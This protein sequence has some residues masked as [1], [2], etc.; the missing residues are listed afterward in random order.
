[1]ATDWSVRAVLDQP[2]RQDELQEN[3]QAALDRVVTEMSQ[4]EP[5]S[6][7]S[8]FNRALAGSW[9]TLPPGFA[10]VI[11]EALAVAELTDGAFDPTLGELSELWGFGVAQ[12]GQLPSDTEVAG[13]SAAAGWQR[14]AFDREA[15]RLRQP[16]GVRLDLSAIAKGFGADRVAASLL[17][18]GVSS[19]LIE[20]G[21]ELVGRG[22][23]P[24][25][26]PWWV[27]L[28]DP[29][30]AA[31]PPLRLALCNHAVATSGNYRRYHRIDGERI[32]HSIDP[33]SG[34]L[35]A[36]RIVS[37]SVLAETAMRADALATALTVLGDAAGSFAARYGIAA[38]ILR[39]V[40]NGFAEEITPALAR[41]LD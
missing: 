15:A 7:L 32:G 8:R 17:D 26:Q 3:I 25:G 29:P 19:F 39:Q 38:R 16:G 20:V 13:A 14:L 41:M 28:E 2:E 11:D 36:N 30:E 34:R 5:D 21:G 9:Q 6:D 33:A 18:A 4:W 10:A 24:D 12:I 37:V 1:M 31:L 23:K 27:A 40:D 22:I 35:L